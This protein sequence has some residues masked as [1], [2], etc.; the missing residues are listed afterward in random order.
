MLV[1]IIIPTYNRA[2]MLRQTLDSVLAQTHRALEVIVV[3]NASTDHTPAVM[4]G[5][6]ARD[7]RIRYVRKPVNTGLTHSYNLGRQ[8]STAE[9]IHFLD[10]DDT[11]DPR[12]T[13]WQL[14][15]FV[16]DPAVDVVFS[17][18]I[19]TDGDLRPFRRGPVLP[20]TDFLRVALYWTYVWFGAS[21]FRR[22]ALDRAGLMDES[23][24]QSGDYDL[25][26]RLLLSGA[27]L[28]YLP[29]AVTHYRLHTNN[30]TAFTTELEPDV[31]A[32]LDRTFADRRLPPALQSEKPAALASACFWFAQGYYKSGRIDDGRRALAEAAAL[33]VDNTRT[34]NALR[35]MPGSAWVG[36]P[37]GLVET[38]LA[39]LP[40]S[41]RW[42]DSY[43]PELL[44]RAHA[45]RGCRALALG[46]P[47]CFAAALR[48]AL[49]ADP[50]ADVTRWRTL[51]TDEARMHPTLSAPR[52]IEA[53]LDAL[54][55]ALGWLRQSRRAMLAQA[56]IESAFTD[57]ALHAP[58]VPSQT[59]RA[60]RHNPRLALNRG[61]L[62]LLLRG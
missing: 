36:D 32:L 30:Q 3:D 49:R 34:L 21:M 40:D 35:E 7:A 1:S 48:S 60:I 43:R 61:V 31:R 10:S 17:R 62:K 41:L 45:A 13:E 8:V 44:W 59:L 55:D 53:M 18:C 28:R 26:I 22:S 51:L 9:Y 52:A 38:V 56:E 29:R 11:I 47:A 57:H 37:V 25:L 4:A 24:K 54:P 39:H 33:T 14:A 20:S 42:V 23:L 12:K 19:H 5:Y 46:D 16:R 6:E 50:E 58:G 15:E 27:T 2:E